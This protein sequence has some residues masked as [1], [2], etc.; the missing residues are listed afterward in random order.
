MA[1]V[2]VVR[3]F[4][5]DSFSPEDAEEQTLDRLSNVFAREMFE[6]EDIEIED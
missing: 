5:P 6:V 2:V 1:T 3:F 4:W